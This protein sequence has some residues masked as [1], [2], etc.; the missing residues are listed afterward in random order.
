[1]GFSP[2]NKKRKT[3]TIALP[4]S[5]SFIFVAAIIVI[6]SIIRSKARSK[7]S[8]EALSGGLGLK[9]SYTPSIYMSKANEKGKQQGH[10]H[11]EGAEIEVDGQ[12]SFAELGEDHGDSDAQ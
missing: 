6:I 11:A 4:L 5:L 10:S 1:M 3:L 7:A 9:P 8:L 12:I 2:E